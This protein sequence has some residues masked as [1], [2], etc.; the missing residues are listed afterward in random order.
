MRKKESSHLLTPVL[1]LLSVMNIPISV[2]KELGTCVGEITL[3]NTIHDR[4]N[5]YV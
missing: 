3:P 1:N 4:K 5:R 2:P